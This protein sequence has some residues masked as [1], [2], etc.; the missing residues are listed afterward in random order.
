MKILEHSQRSKLEDLV[1]VLCSEA[2]LTHI[3]QRLAE[4]EMLL[5]LRARL[6]Q[7]RRLLAQDKLE[8]RLRHHRDEAVLLA[9][10]LLPR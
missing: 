7:E 1:L 5:L 10:G 4:L 2:A 9:R 6:W 8:G 3:R